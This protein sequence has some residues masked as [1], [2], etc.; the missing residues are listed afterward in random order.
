M[1]DLQNVL[2]E[3]AIHLKDMLYYEQHMTAAYNHEV[4]MATFRASKVADYYL[5]IS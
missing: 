1:T 5:Q 4:V 2:W 3:H